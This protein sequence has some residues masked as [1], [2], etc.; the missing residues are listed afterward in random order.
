M[1]AVRPG[2]ARPATLVSHRRRIDRHRLGA[3]GAP[4]GSSGASLRVELAASDRGRHIR[5]LLTVG[6]TVLELDDGQQSLASETLDFLPAAAGPVGRL[7][8]FVIDAFVSRAFW[9]L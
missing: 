6:G 3:V 5:G 2:A 1:R 7:D 9:T 4:S 8:E